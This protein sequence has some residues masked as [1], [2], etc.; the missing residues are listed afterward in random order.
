MQS[1][2]LAVQKEMKEEKPTI[3]M[4]NSQ[5]ANISKTYYS[6]QGSMKL[7]KYISRLVRDKKHSAD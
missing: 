2:L 6:N 5:K 3:P 1:I 7:A 4:W